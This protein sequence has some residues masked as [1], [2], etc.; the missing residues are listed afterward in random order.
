[1]AVGTDQVALKE[2]FRISPACT[3]APAIIVK[4]K[5][6]APSAANITADDFSRGR[7]RPKIAVDD[8]QIVVACTL[9]SP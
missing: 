1:L 9:A 4:A 3:T 7:L 5:V 6:L 2:G 8:K